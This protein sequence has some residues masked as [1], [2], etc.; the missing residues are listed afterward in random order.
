MSFIAFPVRV[1]QLKF[2]HSFISHFAEQHP[3]RS[4]F[5]IFVIAHTVGG[6]HRV[7]IIH[8]ASHMCTLL[9]FT[10]RSDPNLSQEARKILRP[11]F[12][13][14]CFS[15]FYLECFTA[16]FSVLLKSTP[17]GTETFSLYCVNKRCKIEGN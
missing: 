2:A 14:L 9:P 10:S 5:I 8:Q 6:E 11:T 4:T 17:A 3:R 12:P 7:R 1:L 16:L 15:D 13:S